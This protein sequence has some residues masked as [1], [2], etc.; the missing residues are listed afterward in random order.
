MAGS[1]C[2]IGPFQ[3]RGLN[4]PCLSCPR[5][6]QV[7]GTKTPVDLGILGFL[8]CL[9]FPAGRKS[10]GSPDFLADLATL[11]DLGCLGFLGSLGCPDFPADLEGLEAR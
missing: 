4:S 7:Q 11:E 9:D 6:N 3:F 10:L 1:H 5:C 8:G 2:S